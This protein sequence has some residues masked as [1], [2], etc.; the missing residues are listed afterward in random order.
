MD[1]S[2]DQL[3]ERRELLQR[4]LA[5]SPIQAQSYAQRL[6]DQEFLEAINGTAR[7]L[8]GVN[9]KRPVDFPDYYFGEFYTCLLYTSPSPRD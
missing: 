5:M 8:L 2:P 1:V 4:C 6:S 3:D 7:S 9:M